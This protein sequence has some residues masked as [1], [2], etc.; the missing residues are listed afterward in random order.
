MH[1]YVDIYLSFVVIS[2]IKG[3]KLRDTDHNGRDLS[4]SN[5][6]EADSWNLQFLKRDKND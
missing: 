1:T 2:L 4:G 3:G 5:G 6:H